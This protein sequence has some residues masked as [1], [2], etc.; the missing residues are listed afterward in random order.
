MGLRRAQLVLVDKL[1]E[2]DDLLCR[3]A[4]DDMEPLRKQMQADPEAWHMDRLYKEIDYFL[5]H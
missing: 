3:D 5:T 1:D 4:D 2:H